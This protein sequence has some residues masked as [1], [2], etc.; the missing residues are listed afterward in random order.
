VDLLTWFRGTIIEHRAFCASAA[1]HSTALRMDSN[2]RVLQFASY[3]SL[4]P[5]DIHCDSF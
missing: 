1:A 3:V 5:P 2:S 4:I